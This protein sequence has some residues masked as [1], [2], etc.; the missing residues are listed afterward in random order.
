[1]ALDTVFEILETPFEMQQSGSGSK[2]EF[3]PSRCILRI[4]VPFNKQ[5]SRGS[6]CPSC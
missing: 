6:L 1:M 3:Y 5:M 2:E 4:V